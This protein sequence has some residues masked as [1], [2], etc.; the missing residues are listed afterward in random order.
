MLRSSL[1]FRYR[2]L[3]EETWLTLSVLSD[4]AMTVMVSDL[5]PG[6][7]YQFMVLARCQSG[8]E[9]FS[10]E[11]TAPT[12]GYQIISSVVNHLRRPSFHECVRG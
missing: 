7:E 1:S 11:A 5:L 9:Q 4:E 2:R 6:N 3:M 8:E 10:A 12:K